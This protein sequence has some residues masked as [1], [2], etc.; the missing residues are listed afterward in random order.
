[1]TAK[2]KAP[3]KSSAPKPAASGYLDYSHLVTA[4]HST[5]E[6]AVHRA[7]VAVNQW[8]VIRNW[9]V[10]AYLV[11]LPSAEQL[12]ALLEADRARI[13]QSKL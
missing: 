12:K 6:Q 8:L 7:A 10:G 2:K 5:S 3:A 9:L 1:M 4:N 13:E 11:A